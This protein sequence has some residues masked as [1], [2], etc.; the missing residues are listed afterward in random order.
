MLEKRRVRTEGAEVVC[1]T[2]CEE[3]RGAGAL[4]RTLMVLEG[5]VLVLEGVVLVIEGVLPVLEGVVPVL[6][7][8]RCLHTLCLKWKDLTVEGQW[9]DIERTVEGQWKDSGRT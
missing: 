5:V 8:V 4:A 1:P 9:K 3:G 2:G 7:K 6:E